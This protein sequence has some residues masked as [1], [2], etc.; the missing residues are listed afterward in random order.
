[1]QRSSFRARC[2][3][4]CHLFGWWSCSWTFSTRRCTR[5]SWC[6]R[7]YSKSIA[8]YAGIRNWDSY[9]CT[10]GK[11]ISAKQGPHLLNS[12][13]KRAS[14]SSETDFCG[15]RCDREFMTIKN[16]IVYYKKNF[17]IVNYF[18]T[19]LSTLKIKE[20]NMILFK[21]HH[22]NIFDTRTFFPFN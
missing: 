15:T 22:I 11:A 7:L 12:Q 13:D 20:I 3:P 4:L 14:R 5:H 19:I 2:Q 8:T 18:S 6:I 9:D 1:M 17:R 10:P 16:Y 21:I